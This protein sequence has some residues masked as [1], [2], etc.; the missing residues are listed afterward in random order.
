MSK[1]NT[2]SCPQIGILGL[3]L[4]LFA[5]VLSTAQSTSNMLIIVYALFIQKIALEAG[6][7]ACMHGNGITAQQFG[8]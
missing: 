6:A 1:H 5:S 4:I 2:I 8:C 7:V 3:A